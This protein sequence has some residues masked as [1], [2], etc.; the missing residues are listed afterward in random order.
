[1]GIP[2]RKRRQRRDLKRRI[3]DAAERLFAKDG[4]Q[5][6]SMRKIAEEIEYSTTVIYSLFRD[7][8]EIIDDLIAE[9]Y[10]GV[11]R[12]YEEILARRPDSPLETLNSIITEYVAFALENPNHYKLWFATSEIRV[13]DGQLRMRHGGRSYHVYHTWLE[14]IDQC[15]A[16]GLLPDRDTLTLFQLIWGSVHGM[17]SLR[18]HHPQFPWLPL[19]QH[20]KELLSVLNR[21]LA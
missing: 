13:I 7:K 1:M 8:S 17:I 18:I 14:Q 5:N 2:E 9:G 3:L 15:K 12:R 16:E 11:Y 20:V 21:G 6:V 10:R 4:Y 19:K